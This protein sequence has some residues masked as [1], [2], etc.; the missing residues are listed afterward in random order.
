MAVPGKAR[1]ALRAFSTEGLTINDR[2]VDPTPATRRRVASF[3]VLHYGGFHLVYLL[4]L[5]TFSSTADAGGFVTVANESTG[6]ESVV[7]LGRVRAIDFVAFLA[8]AAG[9]W[10]S[11]RSSH[12]EH[13]QADL[14]NRP[15][16]GTLMFVPYA[17]VLPMHLT[18]ILAA[19]LGGGVVWIFGLLKTGADVIMHKVEH[20]LLRGR[21][22]VARAGGGLRDAASID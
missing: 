15:N 17:R 5:A 1:E 7:Q 12:H 2:P 20:R 13:L 6:V 22:A 19:P 14:G 16:L 11:H 10:H 3:F 4:F 21:Q 9:F 8:L 18:I